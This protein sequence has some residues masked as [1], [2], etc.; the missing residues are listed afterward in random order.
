MSR[1]IIGAAKPRI[2]GPAKLSGTATYAADHYPPG[3]AY[4]YGV[5][6]SVAAG[7]IRSIDTATAEAMPGV[8]AVLHHGNFPQ[9]HRAPNQFA[10]GTKVDEPRL[11]FE[12]EQVYYP[13]QFV[14]LVVADSFAAA[15]SAAAQVEVSYQDKPPTTNLAQGMAAQTPKPDPSTG[16]QRGDVDSAWPQAA[17]RLDVVYTTPVE[18]HNPMEMHATTA[19][20]DEAQQRLMF[21]ESTQGVMFARNTMAAIFG[22]APEQVEA[23]SPY[24]GSGFGGKAWIWPH[25]VACAAAARRVGR[26]VQLVVPRAYMF[27]TTGHRAATHQHIRMGTD[28][29]GRLTSLA[30]DTVNSTSPVGRY[31]EQCGRCTKL[32]Y[33]CDNVQVTHATVAINHGTP[34]SMRA[35]GATPGM[36]ALESAM[37]EMALQTGLDPVEFRRRNYTDIDGSLDK[38]FSSNHLGK[39]LEQGAQRFGWSRRDPRPGSMTAG[40]DVL[41]WGMAVA[42]WEAQK[43]GASARVTLG[44]DGRVQVSCATQDIGTGTYTVLA[45]VAAAHLGVPTASVDVDIGDSRYKPGPI[46]GGSWVTASVVPSVTQAADAAVADL[47]AQAVAEGGVLEGHDPETLGFDA[48]RLEATDGASFSVAEVLA[49]QRLASASGEAK[50]EAGLSED[51]SY[52]SFGAH[53]V[54]VRW[55]PGISRLRV[56]RVVSAIDVGRVVNKRMAANQVEGAIAMG[57]GMALFEATEYDPHS[58]RPVNN[59]YAEYLVPT[60]ADFPEVDVILLDYPDTNF[61]EFGARGIGEIGLTGLPAAIANAVH[62][63]TGRRVRD[64]PIRLDDLMGQH[65]V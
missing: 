2:D 7:R 10:N 59:D 36:F 30:H 48:G 5:F 19:A 42:N 60:H 55:D 49:P 44:R 31:V 62:H 65:A 54:E 38:P 28:A 39:A 33:A 23:R 25:A 4:A 12:D 32:L 45:Q 27:T 57:I 13:G 56:A 61:S 40:H 22:L 24:I 51:Y 47:K 3:L 37:D 17:H 34:T 52:H 46:S 21:Y 64:L 8:I 18:T 15:R 63:A 1:E 6:S 14:A 9:L 50:T 41:G 16:H 53:F 58:G 35:P 43:V 11:P 20:W 29:Q 26:P